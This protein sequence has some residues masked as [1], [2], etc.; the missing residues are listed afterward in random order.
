MV[1]ALFHEEAG[2]PATRKNKLNLM[3]SKIASIL[4]VGVAA[5]ILA[6]PAQAVVKGEKASVAALKKQLNA[7]PKHKAPSFSKIQSLVTQ[8]I[9][10]DPKNAN[11]YLK[12]GLDKIAI[13]NA[14]KNASTLTSKA[15]A[16]VNK[17]K[18]KLGAAKTKSI[19][20]KNNGLL[21]K[22][23]PPGPN[24]PPYQAMLSV[25]NAVLA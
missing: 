2:Q 25:R 17:Q 6:A 9:A 24:N 5:L 10:K 21:K 11:S 15:N 12:T 8:L 23:V 13:S 7:L 14:K 20:N 22:Y 18:K 16:A 1:E 4:T 19:I 3:I